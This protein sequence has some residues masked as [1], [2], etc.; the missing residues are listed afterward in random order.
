MKIIRRASDLT[1]AFAMLG[2]SACVFG[3]TMFFAGLYCYLNEASKG[4][5]AVAIVL[6]AMMHGGAFLLCGITLVALCSLTV[7][8]NLTI[9]K[10]N[11]IWAVSNIAVF[12]SLVDVM[13]GII[14]DT[15][16]F[17]MIVSMTALVANGIMCFLI[18]YSRNVLARRQRVLSTATTSIDRLLWENSC[19]YTRFSA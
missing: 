16:F 8:P 12:I 13:E 7:I 1:I 2:L 11:V 6:D 10:L 19:R 15:E 14:T 3:G 18:Y 9:Q 4:I 5:K 17:G